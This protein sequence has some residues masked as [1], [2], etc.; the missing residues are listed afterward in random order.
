MAFSKQKSTYI[1]EN[2]CYINTYKLF[3][4]KYDERKRVFKTCEHSSDAYISSLIAQSNS[5]LCDI[6]ILAL[7]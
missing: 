4:K 2:I 5:H 1:I 7:M 3:S 6:W